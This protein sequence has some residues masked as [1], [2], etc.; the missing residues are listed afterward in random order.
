MAA[1]FID[2]Q[3]FNADAARVSAFDAGVQHAVGL[4]ETFLGGMQG[5][6]AW[7]MQLEDHLLR[8]VTSARELGL[9]DEL[10][11]AGLADAVHAT[12]REAALPL[13]RVRLTVTGGDLNM[14]SRAR[15]G[16]ATPAP[17]KPT[18]MVHAQTATIYP[19]E[20][21]QKGVSVVMADLRVNPLDPTSGH[22]TLNYWARLRELQRAALARAGEALIFQVTNHLAG[23]C[24][25]NAFLVREERGRRTLCTPIARG[26]EE[27]VADAAR[28]ASASPGKP[29]V[30]LP[31]PVLPG[32][33]REW[34]L[35]RAASM[36]LAI[37]R[38]MITLDDVL[39][40]EEVFLSNSSWGI[41]PVIKVESHEIAQGR[42]GTTT[43]E[44]VDAWRDAVDR[45]ARDA[46][47][48]DSF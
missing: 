45:T 34:V 17:A 24:V 47:S 21:Y 27:E 20:L 5:G 26:E 32:V 4:F 1:T 13:A 25:S 41:M 33:V 23:G 19:A 11:T 12:L 39:S 10:R 38:R 44:L 36:G 9:S 15:A 48:S 37:S 46:R 28:Q 14:L 16:D 42:V 35:D 43:G 22:K 3:F 2:G 7:A 8:L 29:G 6:N 18:I 30:A 31:S 40:A